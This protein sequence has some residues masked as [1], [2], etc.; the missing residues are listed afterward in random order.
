MTDIFEITLQSLN[1]KIEKLNTV[2]QNVANLNTPGYIEQEKFSEL[3]DGKIAIE[4]RLK[5]ENGPVNSTGRALDIALTNGKQFFE[6]VSDEKVH[7]TKHGR[8]HI[9]SDGFIAHL[10]GVL[11]MGEKG[12]ISAEANHTKITGDGSV[13]VRGKMI[14][15][16]RVVSV[17]AKSLELMPQGRNLFSASEPVTVVDSP[18][19]VTESL[20]SS[21]VNSA[22]QML[23]MIDLS[24]QIQTSQKVVNAYD[25]LLNAGINELGK[26]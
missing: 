12:P 14:D 15:K 7:L 20:N 1:G 10:S 24:R 23:Q 19:L 6:L 22:Q 3:I 8:F 16:I 21:N 25:Q 18:K 11:L 9:N 17:E 2:S 5:L 13:I 26:K 4:S